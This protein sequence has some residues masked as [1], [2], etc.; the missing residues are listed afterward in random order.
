MCRLVSVALTAGLALTAAA[1]SAQTPD[2][3]AAANPAAARI[4]EARRTRQLVES[5]YQIGQVER[6]LEGAVEHGATQIRD[7]LQRLMPADMLLT[8][9]ARA[10]GFRLEGYGV[11]FDVEVPS[12][13]GSLPWSFQT[14]DQNDLGVDNALKTLRTFVQAAAA[15]DVNLQQALKRI[16]L[17]VAPAGAAAVQ[18]SNQGSPAAGGFSPTGD[19]PQDP[20]LKAPNDEYR[21]QIR[22]AL[23]DAM[24]EHSRGLNIAPA[25]RLTVAARSSEDR[26]RLTAADSDLRTVIISVTGADLTA[27][28]GGQLPRDEARRRVEVR[29]F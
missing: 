7:R 1:G 19:P 22:E 6:L 24:L 11:F 9:N 25:E 15:D 23:I 2:P 28:L 14:L 10:R 26:L 29:V 16:E 21:S 17:Q 20:I 18:A 3:G 13:Q 8:E 4:E 27:F 12:L 5:R